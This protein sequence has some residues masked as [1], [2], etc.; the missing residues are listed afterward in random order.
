M[1]AREVATTGGLGEWRGAFYDG[2]TATRHD[3]VVLL[4][5]GA[6]RVL[7]AEV[8]EVRWPYDQVGVLDGGG[9]GDPVRVARG[10]D[11]GASIVV[12]DPAFRAAMEAHLRRRVAG[13]AKR[14][15]W[16]YLPLI[17][18]VVTGLGAV[19]VWGIP[20]L[21]GRVAARVPVE[22][23]ESIGQ[24]TVRTLTAGG[25]CR[26][27][28]RQE[29]MERIIERLTADGRGGRYT[30][31]VTI[32]ADPTVNALAAPG[33]QLVVFHGL[34]AKAES[35]EEVAGVLAH[36]V[37]HVVRQ[38]GTRS[39]LREIPLRLLAAVVVGDAGIASTATDVALSLGSLRYQ[40]GDE[41]DADTEG[42]LMLEAAGVS[43][44]GLGSFLARLDRGNGSG[45]MLRYLSTHPSSAE[46]LARLDLAS[47]AA[48]DT[49]PP[50]LSAAE[51]RALT[52][53][54]G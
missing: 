40:R 48:R 44:G 32:L 9:A 47:R 15:F 39:V 54:C 23:E 26:G 7:G 36:E 6:V 1:S 16:R 22:W 41:E 33:G 34:L 17:V 3:V 35:P 51:W 13:S 4:D 31:T 10:P 25:V 28:G 50:L 42:L 11:D 21:A 38:H 24:Q 46:R 30:Y 12:D 18:A 49:D 8:G 43:P 53:P 20:A 37:Q 19:Y 45:P 27:A 5:R 2:V 14:P 29:A 52:A